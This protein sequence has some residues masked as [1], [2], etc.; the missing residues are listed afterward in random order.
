MVTVMTHLS[1]D[2]KSFEPTS[3][4]TIIMTSSTIGAILGAAFGTWFSDCSGRR[5]SILAANRFFFVGLIVTISF[6]HNISIIIIGR[7]IFG[8]GI[9]LVSMAN[10]L[11]VS[12]YSPP[13]IRGPLTSLI[14]LVGVL[15]IYLSTWVDKT[16]S[17][18][19]LFFLLSLTLAFYLYL[20]IFNFKS[21]LGYL[22]IF[23]F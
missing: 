4:Q 20:L 3:I 7:L 13:D 8:F 10:P 1:K 21:L 23:Y 19:F 6:Q 5:Q 12:E 11:F 16:F 22:L 18:V 9:G 14:F 17:E 2:F 15:G